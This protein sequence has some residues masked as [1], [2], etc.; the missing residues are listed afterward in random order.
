MS[1]EP[2]HLSGIKLKDYLAK[3]GYHYDPYK[4]SFN[5][6]IKKLGI[7]EDRSSHIAY[8]IRHVDSALSLYEQ[9]GKQNF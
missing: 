9:K 3:K 1:S 6:F 4:T 5:S 7:K 2:K 8:D